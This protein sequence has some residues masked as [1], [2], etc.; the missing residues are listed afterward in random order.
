MIVEQAVFGEVRGGHT[1][2][3]ATGDGRTAAE[4]ASRLDLPDTAPLGVAWSPFVVGFPYQDRYV[5][6]R[7][8][9][10]PGVVRAGMVL[11]HAL[12][13]PLEEIVVASDLRPLFARLISEPTAPANLRTLDLTLGD[14]VPPEAPDLPAAAAALA[15]HGAGPVVRPGTDG[16]DDLVISLWGRLWPAIRRSFVFRLSFGPADVVETPQPTLVCTPPG[17]VSRWRGHRLLDARSAP[18]TSLAA[19]LLCGRRE[20]ESLRAFAEEIGADISSFNHLILLEK[21]HQLSISES[22]TIG[23]TLAAVRLIDRLSPDPARGAIRKADLLDRLVKH[24]GEASVEDVLS[25][26]NLVPQGFKETECVWAELSRW[27]AKNTF[28]P[29]QD[30]FFILLLADAIDASRSTENWR[31]A[32]LNGMSAA[33]RTAD[34]FA[35]AFWRWA[36]ADPAIV[37]PVLTTIKADEALEQVLIDTAPRTLSLEAAHRILEFAREQCL[38]RLHGA[39]AAAA[40][41]PANAVR[42]QAATEPSPGVEGI[43]LALRHAVPGE[44][45]NCAISLAD[46]RVIG[47]AAECVADDPGLLAHVDLSGH[48]A[49]VIWSASLE[50]NPEAWRGPTDPRSACE[51]IL[52]DLLDGRAVLPEL[53]TRLSLT[54]LA[55]LSAFVRRTELWPKLREPARSDMLRATARGWLDQAPGSGAAVEPELQTMVLADPELDQLL[56]RLAS[57][58]V[59]QAVKVVGALAAF[60]EHRFRLW[61][62]TAAIRTCPLPEK[63]SEAIGRLTRERRWKSV[64][65]ELLSMLRHGRQDTRPALRACLSLIGWWDRWRYDLTEISADEKW[66]S[67]EALAAELY[68]TGPG[69]N[70]LWERAGGRDADLAWAQSGRTQWREAL[71]RTRHGSTQPRIESL[72]HQMRSDFPDNS[73]L[74]LLADDREFGDRR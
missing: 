45:V 36:E 23:G 18:A 49:Q 4:L 68:P 46:S 74:S 48:T 17:L 24:L 5:L 2:R 71:A 66:E 12:I 14:K 38:Y 32:I 42:L 56:T 62:R 40:F 28:S 41:E 69:Y 61:L 8:F 15:T 31:D 53:I 43:R 64:A 54:P 13:T 35:R 25:L 16:F 19:A 47:L 27:L 21:A 10:D 63:D 73:S 1:L 22:S 65:D 51:T 26:R 9:L 60:R 55:D 37:Q 57:G 29:L 33:A 7:I 20:S 58:R 11:S 3:V 30:A 70:G 52:F 6:A 44:I 39:T 59:G 34:H 67:L 72:L 50:H